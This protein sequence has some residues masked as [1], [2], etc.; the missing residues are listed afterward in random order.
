M[1]AKVC[2]VHALEETTGETIDSCAIPLFGKATPSVFDVPTYTNTLSLAVLERHKNLFSTTPGQTELAEHFIPT[3][4]TPVKV[5][6][7]RIPAKYRVEIEEQIQ[8]M[9]K[10]EIIEESSSPWMSPAVFVRI[11]NGDVRICVDYRALNKQ[12]IKDTYRLPRPNE[13]QDRLAG[14]TIFST[15]DLRSGYWQFLVH[16]D[17]A[18]TNKVAKLLH[19]QAEH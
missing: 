7:R 12:T 5:P 9:P 4:G 15:L 3:T 8:A 2:A 17:Q 14:C 19:M 16:K 1:K 18:K 6:P 11:K 13:V 10:E